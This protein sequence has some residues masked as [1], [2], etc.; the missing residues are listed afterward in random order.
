LPGKMMLLPI[1]S[2]IDQVST[3]VEPTLHTIKK[4][5]KKGDIYE[6]EKAK[7]HT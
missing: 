5:D 6:T 1:L 7:N 3:L 4:L 2:R